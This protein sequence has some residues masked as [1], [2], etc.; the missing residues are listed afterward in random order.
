MNFESVHVFLIRR[1]LINFTLVKVNSII[2][3]VKGYNDEQRFK[4]KIRACIIT[5]FPK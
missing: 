4:S 2:S 3:I 1:F 5:N